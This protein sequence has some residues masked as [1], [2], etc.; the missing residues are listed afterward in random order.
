[1]NESNTYQAVRINDVAEWRLLCCI[2]ETG[3]SAYLKNSNPTEEIKVLFEEKWQA[4]PDS[5]LEKIENAVYDHPQ[6][7]D[8][9][10]ADIVIVAPKSIWVPTELV[11]DDEENA[12]YLYN[13]VYDAEDYDVM[14]EAMGDATNLYSLVPGLNAFLQRTFPGARIH[15][16]IAVMAARFR[17]RNSDM[18]RIYAEIRSNKV[19]ILAFDRR[20]LLMAATHTWHEVSDIQYHLFNIMNVYGLDPKEVQVSLSG[21]RDEKNTLMRELRKS[22]NYVML[23]MLPSVGGKTGMPTP[24]ALLLR[25]VL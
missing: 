6:V 25:G 17:E 16:H 20:N 24:L 15:S 7:L 22:V 18:P 8:D 11:E 23:T 12:A 19:D 14:T 10:T 2:S 4:D 21:L 9:F 1:M 13:Q 3:I 5:L